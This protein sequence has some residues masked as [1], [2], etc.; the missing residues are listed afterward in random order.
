M[1][2]KNMPSRKRAAT[3]VPRPQDRIGYLLWQTFRGWQR[4]VEGHLAPLELSHAQFVL[5]ATLQY[6]ES[7]GEV[8]SQSRLGNFL[9]FE[10]MMVSKAI[11]VLEDRKY[12]RRQPHP[13]DPR[14]NALGL[15]RAGDATASA[16]VEI[17]LGAEKMYFKVLGPQHETLRELLR[18]T[19]DA[20]VEGE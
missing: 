15:T 6:L 8:P 4:I 13:E 3:S 14:A 11:R 19:L 20:D 18:A 10:P 12:V 17:A 7:I 9:R 1:P 2:H 5:L 16:A